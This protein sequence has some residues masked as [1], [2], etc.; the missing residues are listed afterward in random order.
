MGHSP[1]LPQ[2]PHY[3][4]EELSLPVLEQWIGSERDVQRERVNELNTIRAQ[5]ESLQT[6]LAEELNKLREFSETDSSAAGGLF[7]KL[8]SV[9]R[10]NSGRPQTT[11]SVEALL[12]QQY[13]LSV[14]RLREAADHAD[15]LEASEADLHDEIERL[16]R[17]IIDS[18]DN[19]GRASRYVF[20]L[21]QV[22]AELQN[23]KANTALEDAKLEAS[24]DRVRR[25]LIT[26]GTRQKLYGTARERLSRL[27]DNA[28]ALAST[29]GRLRADITSYVQVAGQ[30]LDMTAGQVQA[31]GA[32]ADAS[33]VVL[34]LEAS[35]EALSESMNHAARFVADT[36]VYFR[37]N[38]DSMIDQMQI[39]DTETAALLEANA[40]LD[41]LGDSYVLSEILAELDNVS[42]LDEF[43]RK[44]EAAIQEVSAE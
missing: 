9:I 32:A 38:V 21:K 44:L 39:Y 14:K 43:E 33:V 17:R 8:L 36:Q 5:N 35:L 42:E 4:G 11:H 13:E 1:D 16:N 6:S 2:P 27:R 31:L 34:E 28:R 22:A 18:A 12:R 24:N 20:E 41:R 10:P 25:L 29:I 3:A 30:K 19:H 15:R 37:E 40:E 26:H 7:A 23:T